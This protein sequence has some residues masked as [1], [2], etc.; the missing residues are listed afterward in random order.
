V[1]TANVTTVVLSI[2][3]GPSGGKLT[4]ITEADASKGIATLGGIKLSK[5][6]SYTLEASD[7]ALI[8]Q[9][10]VTFGVTIT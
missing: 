7:P 10:P 8:N 3:S 9:T 4:G 1:I 5:V 6:G 2:Q